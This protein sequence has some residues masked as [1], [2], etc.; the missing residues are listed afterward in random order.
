L[1]VLAHQAKV[2]MAGQTLELM[3]ALVAVV[4]LAKSAR[5]V[6]VLGQATAAMAS[7]LHLLGGILPLG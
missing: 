6:K 3:T 2:T 7:L 1:A 5:I 4:A